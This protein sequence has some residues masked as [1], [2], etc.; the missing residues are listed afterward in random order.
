MKEYSPSIE[1]NLALK[2]GS[3]PGTINEKQTIKHNKKRKSNI[4]G[5]LLLKGKTVE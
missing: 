2:Q 1:L 3:I 5:K 4:F